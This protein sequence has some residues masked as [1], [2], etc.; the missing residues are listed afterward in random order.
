MA[1]EIVNGNGITR[2]HEARRKYY[3][4]SQTEYEKIRNEVNKQKS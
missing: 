1:N 2:G 4:I 3:G